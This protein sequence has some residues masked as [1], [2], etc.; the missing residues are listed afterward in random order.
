MGT[1]LEKQIAD[2]KAQINQLK[3]GTKDQF[4]M[5]VFSGDMDKILSLIHI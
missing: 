1:E 3:E 4:S 2:L 5:V